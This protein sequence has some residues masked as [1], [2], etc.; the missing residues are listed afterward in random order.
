MAATEVASQPPTRKLSVVDTL[1]QARRA[2]STHRQY[3]GSSGKSPR[4]DSGSKR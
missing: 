3:S 2:L 4:R 1:D